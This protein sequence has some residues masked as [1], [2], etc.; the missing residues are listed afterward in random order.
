MIK[1][2]INDEHSDCDE[3]LPSIEY[4]YTDNVNGAHNEAIA[5]IFMHKTPNTSNQRAPRAPRSFNSFNNDTRVA[6][7]EIYYDVPKVYYFLSAGRLASKNYSKKIIQNTKFC[8][9]FCLKYI[10]A[11]S[12]LIK[13]D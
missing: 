13:N 1:T 8:Q 6:Q 10:L 7:A 5:F 3:L 9:N 4:A 12:D 11:T 2:F